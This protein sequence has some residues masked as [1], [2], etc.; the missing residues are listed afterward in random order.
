LGVR[1]RDGGE[2][3]LPLRGGLERGADDPL[4]PATGENRRLDRGLVV[5]S[6]VFPA[7]DVGV[8]AFGVLPV[9]DEVDVAGAVPPERALDP[10][11]EDVRALTDVLVERLPDRQQ[12]AV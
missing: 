11:E 12:Q 7:A 2:V 8:L 3:A 4:G 1:L 9:D 6:A 10:L 5:E